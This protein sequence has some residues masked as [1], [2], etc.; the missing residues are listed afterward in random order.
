MTNGKMNGHGTY[1]YSNGQIYDGDYING[2]REGKGRIIYSNK[3]IYEGE[4]KGGHRVEQGNI[5]YSNRNNGNNIKEN[6]DNNEA[7]Y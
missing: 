3:V 5:I 1:K 7:Y 4:F 2:L 6:Y